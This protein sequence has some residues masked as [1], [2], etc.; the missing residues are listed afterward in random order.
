MNPYPYQNSVIL[1]DNAHI[2][3]G[4]DIW[5]L[6]EQFGM[7]SPF[8]NHYCSLNQTTGCRI[9]FLPPYSPEC[10]PVELAFSSIKAYLQR[11]GINSMEG[12][13][14]LYY[15]L[16]KACNVITPKMTWGL[17]SHCGYL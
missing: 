8:S 6:V 13:N 7:T 16:Y 17:W 15:E 10:Q 2:H 14:D 1:V 12:E 5:E 9:E 3:K 4:D 11:I